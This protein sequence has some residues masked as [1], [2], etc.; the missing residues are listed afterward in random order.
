ML[1][2][3]I[4]TALRNIKRDL[5]YSSLNILG[6]A[7]GMSCSI[8]IML[9]V[10]DELSYDQFHNDSENI[11]RII[12]KLPQL[13]VPV[14]PLPLAEALKTDYPEVIESCNLLG[15]ESV[16]K[17][18][19]NSF[20]CDNGFLTTNNFFN[21]FSFKIINKSKDSLLTDLNE[22]VLSEQV[23]EKLFGKEDP[24]GKTVNVNLTKEYIVSGIIQ[25]TPS[26]SHLEYDFF[27]NYKSLEDFQN[28]PDPW[29]VLMGHPYI[30]LNPNVNPDS[31]NNKIK[32]YYDKI[33]GE[34]ER[35]GE[36]KI[37]RLKDIHLKSSHLNEL[38]AKIGDIKYVLIFSIVSIFILFIACINFMN[39]STA[40]AIKRF[41]DVG[42]RKVVGAKRKQ[43]ITQ[44]LSESLFIAFIALLFALLFVDFM[45]P[46][47]NTISQKDISMSVFSYKEIMWL[48]IITII[49]GLISGSYTAFYL[50]KVKSSQ[51]LSKE[52][53]RG[54]KG[55]LFR[56]VLVIMQF[57]I[58]ISLIIFSFIVRSQMSYIQNKNLGYK[59][60]NLISL[61]LGGDFK[62]DYNNIKSK[63]LEID[64]INKTTSVSSLPISIDEGTYSTYWP[65]KDP[66][67]QHLINTCKTDHEFIPCLGLEL[68]EG[69]NFS[70]II[71]KDTASFIVNE[72]TVKLMELK[73]PIGTKIRVNGNNGLIIGILKDFHFKSIHNAI[74][75]LIISRVESSE[76]ILINIDDTNIKSTIE[77]ISTIFA[78]SFPDYSLS[79]K[80]LNESYISLYDNEKRIGKIFDY[81]A[82][83]AIF[84][85][86]LGLFGLSAY[87][88][89]QRTKEI[90]IRKA[91][92]ESI[93]A[94]IITLE[95]DFLKW[96]LISNL[97]A[98]PISYYFAQKW[99]ESFTYKVDISI[100]IFIIASI[101]TLIIAI[102]TVL[103]QAYRAAIKNPANSLRYE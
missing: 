6:L 45:L 98:W 26:N 88:A 89:E 85:S 57:T 21:I 75:P 27:I 48:I 22:I 51:I 12:T 44:Y 18:N 97:I 35:I 40:K 87:T 37:Q 79:Y 33:H 17:M 14:G 13:D 90:G 49:T 65:N 99:L 54:K 74:T 71:N 28:L 96:I 23:A 1:K 80:H 7:I 69:R 29:G 52:I 11:Y 8:L 64:G 62:N 20:K 47:F 42:I 95:K 63:L 59:L 2:N 102:L 61:E 38:Y 60:D 68:I 25:N 55:K 16:L 56:Q 36:I 72:S 86:C 53:I 83:L 100:S 34:E 66:H 101:L 3:Y 50:S 67:A 73:N 78:E 84:L 9:W 77:D 46:T 32:Y 93:F 30:K 76:S 91:L 19:N 58:S 4:I 31:L 5:F 103:T 70:E 43:L 94:I 39:L 15:F 82:I 10:Y 92:G 41:T 81:F 24:M